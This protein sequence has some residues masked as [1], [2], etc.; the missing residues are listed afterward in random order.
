MVFHGD[1]GISY[2]LE[3]L[4][5]NSGWYYRPTKK[6]MN[7]CRIKTGH[8]NL[9]SC[10]GGRWLRCFNRGKGQVKHR[11]SAQ[12]RGPKHDRRFE[13]PVSILIMTRYPF[14]PFKTHKTSVKNPR[15]LAIAGAIWFCRSHQCTFSP[16]S[17]HA[18]VAK[19]RRLMTS[20]YPVIDRTDNLNPWWMQSVSG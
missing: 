4:F 2:K 6:N 9:V 16:R 12:I 10:F 17:M 5:M 13:W 11:A 18:L 15:L 3:L 1:I 20:Q 7:I 8:S 19:E 14:L